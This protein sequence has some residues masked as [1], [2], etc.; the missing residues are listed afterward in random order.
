[1]PSRLGLIVARRFRARREPGIVDRAS[2]RRHRPVGVA[3]LIVALV[4]IP[5][6][7]MTALGASAIS[8]RRTTVLHAGHVKESL[9][10]VDALIALRAALHNEQAAVDVQRRAREFGLTEAQASSVLGFGRNVGAGYGRAA[11]NRA[12]AMF[13]A[14]KM[15][16]GGMAPNMPPVDEVQLRNLRA[17]IDR[18]SI[19][20]GTVDLDYGALDDQAEGT[21]HSLLD[22]MAAMIIRV[23]GGY[24]TWS[25]LE[26][27]HAASDGLGSGAAEVSDMTTI[28]LDPSPDV[29]QTL[30]RL[31][32]AT[33][34]YRE[35]RDR[36]GDA[37][38][39]G[40]SNAWEQLEANAAVGVYARAVSQAEVNPAAAETTFRGHP[41]VAAA[42]LHGGFTRAQLLFS[43][44]ARTSAAVNNGPADPS[45][46]TLAYHEWLFGL[47]GLALTS[48]IVASRW[49]ASS[50]AHTAAGRRRQSGVRRAA[51]RRDCDRRRPERDRGR[52]RGVR[53]TR[54]EPPVARVQEPSARELRLQRPRP[55]RAASGHL[56]RSMES[57]VQVLSGSIEERDKLQHR[58]A[59]ATH[60]ALTG[61]HNRAAAVSALEQSLARAH[62]TGD[63]VGLLYI[64]LDDFK[65]ANDNHGHQVG[66]RILKDVG[67]RMNAVVRGGDAARIGGDEFLVVAE[68]SGTSRGAALARR[69]VEAIAEPV[70]Q[71]GPRVHGRR[72]CG[73]GDGARRRGRCG[74][75]SRVP[76]SPCTAPSSGPGDDRDLRRA[77]PG[78]APSPIRCR[79][80]LTVAFRDDD[81]LFVHYQPVIDSGGGHV[82][83]LE[84]LVRWRRA[85]YAG[86]AAGRVHPRGRDERSDHRS[87]RLG[88]AACRDADGRLV[89]PGR[90]RRCAR[91]DQHLRAP[92]AGEDPRQ[93]PRDRTRET[94]IDP[95]Q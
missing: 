72:V 1:M 7:G 33:A 6:S 40:L 49:L 78:R 80:A 46:T 2:G 94:G 15:P 95:R 51:R 93:T 90:I 47:V 29:N 4:L 11:T 57:S 66:D 43:L 92:P 87:R 16:M 82:M 83:T 14:T 27:L 24:P 32:N 64:D 79:E 18:G 54:H 63:A 5:L 50:P 74:H 48:I 21:L 75:C 88:A 76:T 20:A 38:V 41:K 81:E 60:D 17:E 65:R 69:L 19:D 59:Q 61:L 55:Q 68:A 8:G 35:A 12:L 10:R 67:S 30:V 45:S 23:D 26:A 31:G 25:A 89:N 22:G 9:S 70:E 85:R 84:A 53:R 91:R 37:G 86:H 62:R 34:L 13:A 56:G 44:L 77:A 52:R 3:T 39:P 58:L 71:D 73:R 28:A 36:F 42:V